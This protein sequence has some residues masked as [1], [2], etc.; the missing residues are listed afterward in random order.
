MNNI[1]A[2]IVADSVNPSGKRITTF[3]C[4][5]PRFI[6]A[7]IMTH[8]QFSRNAASSRAIPTSKIIEAIDQNPARPEW[9]GANQKGMQANTEISE[10]S[11]RVAMIDI[12]VLKNSA[13]DCV[14]S[15]VGAYG[16]HKQIA[17]RY[18]E[19]WFHITVL[20]TSTEW[21]NFFA[22]RA[23]PD[24]QPEFQ[25]LAYKMLDCYL[26]NTPDEL[27]WEHWHVPFV[28]DK[29]SMSKSEALIHSV[30]CAARTSYTTH[31]GEFGLHEQR[32][33]VD[34]LAVA[35][36]W[37]PFEHQAQADS[38]A[39]VS[40]NFRCGW[41]QYRQDFMTNTKRDVDL[42]S[43]MDAKPDWVKI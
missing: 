14:E 12:D 15:L 13:I 22:L 32:K 2:K 28:T 38:K 35:G 39:V 1:E 21:D 27:D 9:W 4:T 5:Y 19:P 3:L 31:D 8:R 7:E 23:H 40:G 20:I 17:N 25:V 37:S 11:K 34:N 26:N 41:R 36:H 24:A 18:L 16:L 6:H 43:L 42:Q 29:T 10:E 33:L 30:A